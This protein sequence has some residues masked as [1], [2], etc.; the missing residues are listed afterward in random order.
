MGL[1]CEH[2]DIMSHLLTDVLTGL[3]VAEEVR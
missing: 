2:V 3:G 1:C